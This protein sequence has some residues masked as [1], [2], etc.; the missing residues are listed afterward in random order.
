MLHV[1]GSFEI[2]DANVAAPKKSFL[3]RVATWPLRVVA[4]RQVLARFG[5]MDDRELADIGLSRQD[6]RD[7]TALA[8]GE[9]PSGMFAARARER[10]SRRPST[11]ESAVARA[12]GPAGR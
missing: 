9:D 10:R 7:A 12:I 5:A 1:R 11:S 3:R 4:A 8:L 2:P 6:V